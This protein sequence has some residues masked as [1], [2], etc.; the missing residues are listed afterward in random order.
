MKAQSKNHSDLSEIGNDIASLRDNLATL[1]EHLKNGGIDTA[2]GAT[3]DMVQ[4]LSDETQRIYR[5]VRAGGQRSVD[6]ISQRVEERPL[7]SLM[8]AFGLGMISSRLLSR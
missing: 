3:E 7:T 8:I 5:N 6:A 2:K 1:M 4:R